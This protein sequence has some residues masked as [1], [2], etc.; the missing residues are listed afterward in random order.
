MEKRKRSHIEQEV[1]R[2]L[3]EKG[4]EAHADF[5]QSRSIRVPARKRESKLIS[6]RIPVEMMKEL[7]EVAER[8]GLPGYQR[9]IK[10]YIE[11]ALARERTGPYLPIAGASFSMVEDR[12][13]GRD[14]SAS[15]TTTG[16]PSATYWS[17]EVSDYTPVREASWGGKYK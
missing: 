4:L 11:Q 5:D 7:R 6:I 10:S 1:D 2:E 8:K 13:S 16:Q 12:P 9:M 15:Q 17:P 3:R 14:Y